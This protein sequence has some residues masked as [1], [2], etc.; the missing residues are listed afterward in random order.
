MLSVKQRGL[1]YR[2]E[3]KFLGQYVRLSLGT[4]DGK[5]AGKLKTMIQEAASVETDGPE[6]PKLRQH[7]SPETFE[8]LAAISGYAGKPAPPAPSTWQ[9]LIRS[10][11]TATKQRIAI[12][13]L[14]ETTWERYE[15]AFDTFDDFLGESGI[16]ALSAITKPVV[17]RFTAW[18]M[19]QT[20]K[21]K[22]ARGGRGLAL[23]VA[24][25]HRIFSHAVEC[26]LVSK[27][28]VRLEG[29]PGDN[30]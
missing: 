12:G 30:P 13:K 16:T 9:D 15:H 19:E 11:S 6:W 17:E 21:Q 3:G 24:I 27:N 4:R 22:N 25:L 1:V 28:P 23:D 29:R 5:Y 14:R 10:F 18:R 20:L 2:L 26:E 7:L 8:R